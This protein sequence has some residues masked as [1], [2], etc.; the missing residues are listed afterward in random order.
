MKLGF[1]LTS[2][3]DVH[4]QY[5]CADIVLRSI[6]TSDE[7]SSSFDTCSCIVNQAHRW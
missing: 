3:R 5:L 1:I 4:N 7:L 2:L 6:H